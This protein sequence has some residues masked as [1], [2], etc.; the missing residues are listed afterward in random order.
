V[1]CTQKWGGSRSDGFSRLVTRVPILL[2]VPIAAG[3][4]G[5]C[6]I[7]GHI[8]ARARPSEVLIY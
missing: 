1:Y 2:L 7:Q 5:A 4:V 6:K 8:V 3:M